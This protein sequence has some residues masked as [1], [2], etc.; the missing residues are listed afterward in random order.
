MDITRRAA[1]AAAIALAAPQASRAQGAV[2]TGTATYRER[3]A[4]PP[5]AVLEVELRD[6]SRADAP[7][8]PIAAARIAVEG[9]VP[10]RFALPFDAA[11]IEPQGRYGVAAR[12]LPG[13]E[14]GFRSER[15]V[16]VL[17]QGA[18]REVEI[19][20][21]RARGEATSGPAP[22]LVGPAWVA[23][24]IG[25]RGVA[26][27]VRTDITFGADGRAY[28]SGGCNRFTG[29]YT[30]EGPSLRFEAMASTNMACEPPTMDQEQRFHQAL[31]GVR[32]WRIENGILHLTGEGGAPLLRLSRA[33]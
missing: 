6:L 3:I 19:L 7:G 32:G 30:L 10:I 21:L 25:G 5:G 13:E 23:Q 1:L 29:G 24:E 33:G 31:A 9:Q 26:A 8:A 18:G 2:I 16:P 14:V 12:L 11:R 17:T 4:L 22:A 20:L 27:R 28:G 15:P